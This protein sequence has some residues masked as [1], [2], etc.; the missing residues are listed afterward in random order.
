MWVECT[1]PV[2]IAV[3][4]YWGKREDVPAGLLVPINSSLSA[5]IHQDSMRSSTRITACR[6]F[7]ADTMRLN[8]KDESIEA[9]PRM[10]DVIQLLR[11][12]AQVRAARCRFCCA[13]SR[14]A[15]PHAMS[16]VCSRGVAWGLRCRHVASRWSSMV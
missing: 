13:A 7:D 12:R 4:K 11:K 14:S 6:A 16:G 1:A 5:A 15:L 9:N 8:G 2:N 3:I 10:R